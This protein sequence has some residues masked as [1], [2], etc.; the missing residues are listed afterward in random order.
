VQGLASA[1]QALAV[2][3]TGAVGLGG[4]FFTW[5]N[6]RQARE[7]TQQTLEL[8]EQG[9]T[10]DR[11]TRAIDQLGSTDDGRKV[12]EVQLEAIYALERIAAEAYLY[13]WTIVEI[14][15]AYVTALSIKID[16]YAIMEG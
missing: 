12:L 6:T 14:L 2:F 5:R 9:Q 8:T 3:F 1:S 16:P 15:T 13:Y 7:T 4:L 11:F 10:T